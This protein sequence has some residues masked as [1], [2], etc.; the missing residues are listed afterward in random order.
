[1]LTCLADIIAASNEAELRA[2]EAEIWTSANEVDILW[3]TWPRWYSLFAR[4]WGASAVLDELF[5]LRPL[6]AGAM[7]PIVDTEERKA[8]ARSGVPA[9]APE[10]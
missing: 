9:R 8:Q 5:N 7:S 2:I 1:M 3:L 6:P 10:T 4:R